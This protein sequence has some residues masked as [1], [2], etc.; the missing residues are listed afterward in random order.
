VL[1]CS[2]ERVISPEQDKKEVRYARIVRYS[3]SRVR[4]LPYIDSIR[5]TQET[6]RYTST[7]GMLGVCA[8][9]DEIDN[10]RLTDTRAV[11]Q[12]SIMMIVVRDE[13]Q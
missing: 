6:H 13:Q 11:R 2:C 10:H 1:L 7:L 3:M 8:C 5:V 9:I 4:V 12:Y